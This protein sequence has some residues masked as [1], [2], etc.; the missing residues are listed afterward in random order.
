M[1]FSETEVS[2]HKVI[3]NKDDFDLLYRKKENPTILIYKQNLR[4]ES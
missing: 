2:T 3:L 4:P 1:A